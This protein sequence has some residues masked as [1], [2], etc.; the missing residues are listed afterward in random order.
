[1]TSGAGRRRRGDR[2]AILVEAALVLPTL[3]LLV[4]GLADLANLSLQHSQ[5]SSTARDGARTAIL[6]YECADSTVGACSTSTDQAA[7][8][9]AVTRRLAA[10]PGVAVTVRCL[11]GG[12]LSAEP[13]IHAAVDT[14]LVEVTV[15]WPMRPLSFVGA[16]FTPS[17]ISASSRM[18]IVGLPLT[19]PATTTTTGSTTTSTSST[20]TTTVPGTTTTTAPGTCGVVGAPAL[21]TPNPLKARSGSIKG[22]V[23][24]TVTTNASTSCATAS[25]QLL[26]SGGPTA[27]NGPYLPTAHTATDAVFTLGEDDNWGTGT[28]TFSLF[29]NAA[30][31]DTFT[32]SI[33]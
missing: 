19:T 33:G 23:T 31:V 24:V 27:L 20:T 11:D 29:L 2:G 1:V 12:T 25:W 14:D 30:L 8:T 7:V 17:T 15:S 13:C 16:G 28:Y 26:V 5:A 4:L 18:A 22:P 3:L 21:T 10:K 6:H 32:L 9:D